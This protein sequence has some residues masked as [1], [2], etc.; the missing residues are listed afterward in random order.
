[1]AEQTKCISPVQCGNR[2][3][4]TA[5]DA[6]LLKIV[7]MDNIRLYCLNGAILNNDTES[8][9]DCMI[10]ELAVLHLQALGMPKP[11]VKTN[12]L[13]NHK[14]KHYVKNDAGVTKEFYQSTPNCPFFGKGQGKSS[15]PANWLFTCFTLLIAL[16]MLCT[17]MVMV[18][19][20]LRM[21]VEQ[22]AGAY[23]DDTS[24]IYV[25]EEKNKDE[26]PISIRNSIKK[27][28]QTW[29]QLLFGSGGKLSQNKMYWW[30]I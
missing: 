6:L 27:I 29:E 15:S 22:V 21:R 12:V 16:E 28:V 13:F 24:N 4:K 23:V 17:G 9:Y 19:L 18:S 2:R 3:G 26:T 14:A 10:L 25:S 20:C 5:L 7:T 1:M 11:A 30:L 8:C